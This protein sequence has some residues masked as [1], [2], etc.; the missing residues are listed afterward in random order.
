MSPAAHN[1]I[2]RLDAARQKWWLFT[3]MTTAVLATCISLGTLFAFMLSDALLQF[4]Q[5][6]LLG[7]FLTWLAVTI[8]MIVLVC[9]RLVRSHRSL[10][11][12]ARRVEAEFPE[13]GSNL[14]NV[15]QLASDSK[16]MDRA[17]CEAA[18]AHSAA[19]VG[20]VRFEEAPYKE[21]RW[22]RFRDC[23]Q[24]PR[25]L[26]ES[27]CALGALLVLGVLC[28][29]LFPN[30]GSAANRLMKPWEFVPSVGR[31]KIVKVTPEDTDVLVGASLE[32]TAEI[33]DR[34]EGD[35]YRA[36]LYVTPEGGEEDAVPMAADERRT[37]K[38]ADGGETRDE[39]RRLYRLT[40]PSVVKPLAYRIEI[41]DSQTREYSVGV[42]EKP[43]IEEVEV[44]FRFPRYLARPDETFVQKDA[45]LEG[46]QYT[47][48]ELHIRPSVPI[49]RGYIESEGQ[50]FVG[51]VENGGAM[52]VAKV[53]ML[54]DSTFTIHLFNSAGHGDPNPRPNRIHVLPDQ[55]PTVELLKPGRQETASPGAEIPVMIR[56]GDD[57][58]VGRVR[59][60]MKIEKTESGEPGADAPDTAEDKAEDKAQDEPQD[61]PEGNEAGEA[62]PVTTVK[63]WTEFEG[64][65]TVVVHHGLELP[66]DKVRP[67]QTVMIQAVVWDKL[68]FEGWGLDLKPQEKESAWHSIRIVD[69]EAKSSEALEQ[70]DSLRAEIWKILETQL[71][72]RVKAAVILHKQ[73]LGERTSLVGEVRTM[74]VDVQKSAIDLVK[75]IGESPQEDRRT[76]KRIVNQLAFGDML[77]AVQQCDDLVKVNTVAGF[78]Q[79][80]PAL[81]KTQER[82]IDV[83]RKLLDVARHAES[84]ELAEMKKRQG[85][86]LPP[87]AKEKFEDL[88]KKL[89]E[90]LEQQKK[91]VEA[92]ESLAK[93]PVE[94]FAEKEEQLLKA[95]QAAEDDWSKFMK[96]L[97]TD[98]SKLPDQDFANPSMLKEMVEIQTELKM[99]DDALLKKTADIAVPLEQLGAEMAEEIQTNMEK[100]LPDTPDRERWSQE[101]YLNDEL[102]E[103]PMAELPGELEDLIG[104][105]LE[106]EEDLFDE[107]EDVSSSAADSIDKGA[108]WDVADGPISNMSAKG[109]TGNR[110]PNTSEIG[111]RAGE[112]RQG[113]SSGEFVGDEA[114]G[115]GGRKTPSRLT[116]D[117]YMKGQIKDHSKD[118]TGGATGG[119]KESGEG[120]EGLE[121]PT[122]GARD[123]RERNRLAG[124]QAALRNKAEGI[125]LQFQVMNFHHTDLKKMIEL[126][127]QIER[128]VKAGRY[129]NALR[130]RQVLAEKAG[131][132]KQYLEGE[133]EVRQDET[134]NL[135]TDIQKEILGSMQD[136]SPVGWEELNRQYFERLATGGASTSTPAPQPAGKP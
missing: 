105:L 124:K 10:E 65:N 17:F 87:D 78:D 88:R 118:P 117:P 48:A 63:D 7:L 76:V 112:G 69:K 127:A 30:W 24:T 33:V 40:L 90:A 28:H 46:P 43:T 109:A 54:K 70:I 6:V 45:D 19:H 111:G 93:A 116:P 47:V 31:V 85:G 98:L 55:L 79:P 114:V 62:V 131:N 23:M 37:V 115:K 14:I 21:S 51:T 74:Q 20:H 1:V 66:A 60:Q 56:A 35:P 113:K 36:T 58:G 107:M 130:Q 80:V 97:N 106:E 39:P 75:A 53:P 128:D 38:V 27:L 29:L 89:D 129:Q 77:Q 16:N 8:T 41:G 59:L 132:V 25:D 57:H 94:D 125:D 52:L 2:R 96:E 13:L 135:P 119:G 92:A 64:T 5:L 91:V 12:T 104:D 86:D 82:I 133:F 3:L 71:R 99:A 50:R 11:A 120:G 49:A 42:R 102:K 95:L 108:G 73:A 103:A 84:E 18:V 61:K 32:I 83:L 67:G 9:R 81:N 110:L 126:M 26:G 100:W 134:A 122:P 123:E 22:R 136:P 72:A 15:V 4:S 68:D 34:P 121:G 44:T 101:E